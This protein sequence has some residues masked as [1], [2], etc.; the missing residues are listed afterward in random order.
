MI[1]DSFKVTAQTITSYISDPLLTLLRLERLGSNE[2]FLSHLTP[3]NSSRAMLFHEGKGYRK[4][5]QRELKASRLHTYAKID[6]LLIKG[7]NGDL[8]DFNK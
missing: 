4:G 8:D 7:L 3:S 5:W 6:F 1:L 2:E